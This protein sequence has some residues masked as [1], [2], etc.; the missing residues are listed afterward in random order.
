MNQIPLYLFSVCLP[1]SAFRYVVTPSLSLSG[2]YF[3]LNGSRP[4]PVIV[5][6]NC[7]LTTSFSSLLTNSRARPSCCCLRPAE[8]L[9]PAG[10]ALKG[11][12]GWAGGKRQEIRFV[13]HW[14]HSTRKSQ[15]SSVTSVSSYPCFFVDVE[16]HVCRFRID[17]KK[18]SLWFLV[19]LL[20]WQKSQ[21]QFFSVP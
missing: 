8:L 5:K 4:A 21:F 17:W 11:V 2:M 18:A 20:D 3:P 19:V 15:F 14:K 9:L 6:E 12:K 16:T 10:L 7:S 13:C 1:P